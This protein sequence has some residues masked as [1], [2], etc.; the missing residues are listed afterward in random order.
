MDIAGAE[1][2]TREIGASRLEGL[3]TTPPPG[4]YFPDADSLNAYRIIAVHVIVIH[5]QDSSFQHIKKA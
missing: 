1:Y 3:S 4:M 5:L 2:G